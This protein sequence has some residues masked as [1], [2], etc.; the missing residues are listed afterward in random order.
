MSRTRPLAAACCLLMLA[1]LTGA[2]PGATASIAEPRIVAENPVNYTPHLARGGG[3]RPLALAVAK[4]RDTMYVGGRFRAVQNAE[5][6]R[7]VR[8]DNIVAFAASTGR[9]DRRFD[10][11]INGDVWAIEAVRDSVYVGG[12]FDRVNGVRRPAIV[13]LDADTGAV[14]RSFDAPVRGGRVSEIRLV[15]RRLLVGG[16]FGRN[17]LALRPS[18]GRNTGY[19]DVRIGGRLP[20][21]TSR[22]EV[23]RFAVSPAGKRLVAVGNFTTVA[24]KF[25]KRAFML[26]L[27]GGEARLSR[28]Y[29]RPLRDRCGSNPRNPSKQPYLEDVDFSP[30]GRYFVFASTGFVPRRRSQIGTHLC[31]AAARFETR[32]LSPNRPTWVNYTGGDTL[33]AVAVTGSA[34]YVQGHNRWLDNPYGR[35]SKGRGAVDRLGIGAI[36]PRTGKALPWNPDKPARQGGQDFL[37]TG[38]G[39]WVPSDSKRFAGEYHR[40]IAFVPQR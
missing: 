13:K 10:P 38:G 22:V 27:R 3:P 36:N 25:R 8:R 7:T 12:S 39:L 14:R 24:E 11:S 21:T 37:V 17:L 29:Y 23:F 2:G 18:S 28:W 9:I 1:G 33:H 30:S 5:R 35:N 6:T 40:G 4:H 26:N 20:M 31:D 19:L 16:S 34:V 15:D 32:E